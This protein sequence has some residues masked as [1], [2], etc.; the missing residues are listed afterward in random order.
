MEVEK[1]ILPWSD[2]VSTCCNSHRILPSDKHQNTIRRWKSEQLLPHCV[3]H[4]EEV[5]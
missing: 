1:E 3:S 5:S 2:R 4:H